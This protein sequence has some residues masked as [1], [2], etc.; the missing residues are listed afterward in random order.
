MQH[1]KL[2]NNLFGTFQFGF[3]ITFSI[4]SP[5]KS[6]GIDDSCEMLPCCSPSVARYR[7]E[8]IIRII[9]DERGAPIIVTYLSRN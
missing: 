2:V 7:S 8:A 9:R 4:S 6:G 3:V 5:H 1:P